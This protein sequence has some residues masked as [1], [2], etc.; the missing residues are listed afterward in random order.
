L[1]RLHSIISTAQASTQLGWLRSDQHALMKK[2]SDEQ[3]FEK[4][5]AEEDLAYLRI[6]AGSRSNFL[7]QPLQHTRMTDEQKPGNMSACPCN[8]FDYSQRQQ[9]KASHRVSSC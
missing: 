9:K 6:S 2:L 8:A 3:A 4:H 7:S 1:L 5:E